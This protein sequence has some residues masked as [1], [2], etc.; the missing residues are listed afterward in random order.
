MSDPD[1]DT[2]ANRR[3]AMELARQAAQEGDGIAGALFELESIAHTI[4]G[5]GFMATTAQDMR[6]EDEDDEI[7]PF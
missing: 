1:P 7:R 2:L 3:A 6:D 4:P 5:G